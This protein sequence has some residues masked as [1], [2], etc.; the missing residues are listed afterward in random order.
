MLARILWG[1]CDKHYTR[2]TLGKDTVKQAFSQTAGEGIKHYDLW[3]LTSYINIIRIIHTH[4]S[5]NEKQK[6]SICVNHHL[7]SEAI[8]TSFF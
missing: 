3:S 2:E 8:V 7:L 5:S 4:C 1:K 6:K